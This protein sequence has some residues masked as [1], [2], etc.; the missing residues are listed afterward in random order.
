[1]ST[2]GGSSGGAGGGAVEPPRWEVEGVTTWQGDAT[3]A[4]TMFYD[5]T[6]NAAVDNQFA[7]VDGALWERG[8]RASFGAIAQS[9]VSRGLTEQLLTLRAHGHEIVNHSWSHADLSMSPVDIAQEIDGARSSLEDQ[10]GEAITFFIFPFDAFTDDLVDHLRAQGYLGARAG[11]RGHNPSDFDDDFRVAFDV[12][13]PGY[14]IYA[15][16]PDSPCAETPLDTPWD[17]S[18]SECRKY[19]LDQYV[20]DV[21]ASGGWGVREMHSVAGEAWEPVP[22]AEYLE[23]LDVV[24]EHVAARR[25]WTAPASDVIRY[26]RAREV[27]PLPTVSGDQL[28]FPAATGDCARYATAL[29]YRIAPLEGAPGSVSARQ[30]GRPIDVLAGSEGTWLVTA[31]PSRGPVELTVP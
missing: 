23:H 16:T 29:T 4:Y 7:I 28:V 1:M 27:C 15:E 31:D 26:R 2:G 20:R 5:D 13:G 12:F 10:L 11:V 30:E 18:S 25:L 24:K 3:A 21:I 14:S 6:C 19:V 22:E 17:E 8:L 9:C